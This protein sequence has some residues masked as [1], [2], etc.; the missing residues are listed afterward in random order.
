MN[1]YL[2]TYTFQWSHMA[3]PSV[4]DEWIEAPTGAKARG[5]AIPKLIEAGI[6]R[7]G[8]PLRLKCRRVS[9]WRC[10]V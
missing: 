5:I 2:I 6:H 9:G 3:A 1:T 10:Y 7:K 8:A 4:Y